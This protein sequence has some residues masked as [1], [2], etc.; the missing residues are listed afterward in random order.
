MCQRDP[1]VL[2]SGAQGKELW[3]QLSTKRLGLPVFVGLVGAVLAV[4]LLTIGPGI[5]HNDTPGSEASCPICHVAHITAL[6]GLP[7]TSLA[8]SLAVIWLT[9]GEEL[10]TPVSAD[11][12]D[13][14]PRAPPR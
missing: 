10:L 3:M 9:L 2:T 12:C 5:W 7:I 4:L 1:I 6:P 13:S 11:T 14:S 8:V